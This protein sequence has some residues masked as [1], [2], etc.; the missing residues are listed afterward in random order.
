[1]MHHESAFRRVGVLLSLLV[2]SCSS[3]DAENA[4]NTRGVGNDAGDGG[5]PESGAGSCQP[6]SERQC[7]T[8]YPGVCASGEQTATRRVS[9]GNACRLSLSE[10]GRRTA[11]T[12]S[13]TIVTA[14]RTEEDPDCESCAPGAT[15]TCSTT[16]PGAC[17]EG[18]QTCTDAGEWGTCEPAV[19]PNTQP[20]A[21]TGQDDD[22]DGL[23]DD[24]D[25]DLQWLHVWRDRSV[26]IGL[27]RGLRRG[28]AHLFDLGCLGDL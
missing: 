27:R 13:M 7:T 1:M 19:V 6:G 4:S 25:P 20:E 5:E 28:D 11:R 26:Y 8:S 18:T 17:S 16:F 15:K 2:L 9:G 12:R 23:V 14:C 10:V 3:S 21:C 22:C 24:D